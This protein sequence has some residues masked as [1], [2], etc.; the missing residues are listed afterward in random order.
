MEFWEAKANEPE[1]REQCL[2][3]C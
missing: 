3:Q 2:V 1:G